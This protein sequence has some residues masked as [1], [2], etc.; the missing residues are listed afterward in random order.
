MIIKETKITEI[1]VSELKIILWKEV[2]DIIEDGVIISSTNFRTS[3]PP[4]TDISTLPEE[5]KPYAEMLW[6]PEVIQAYLD[7][8]NRP[9]PTL[10][11]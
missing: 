6:T 2:T 4:G 10:N 5:I 7:W 9:T 8:E 1:T 11:N 3:A